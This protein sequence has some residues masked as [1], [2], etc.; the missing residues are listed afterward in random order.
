MHTRFV[1]KGERSPAALIRAETPAFGSVNN[2]RSRRPATA[3]LPRS[4]VLLRRSPWSA[5]VSNP[6]GRSEGST[7]LA[8]RRLRASDELS[9]LG[10]RS[11]RTREVRSNDGR[12]RGI[13]TRCPL[14]TVA[15][16]E[17]VMSIMPPRRPFKSPSPDE[18]VPPSRL[19]GRRDTG[20][21]S[22][23]PNAAATPAPG[24]TGARRRL[25]EFER[26][27]A[28]R[29]PSRQPLLLSFAERRVRTPSD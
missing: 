23:F 11:L 7:K 15:A 22:P 8:R 29:D 10:L 14:T 3:R 28:S 12:G 19:A 9:A 16:T 21:I 24:R 13:E 20:L 18:T 26:N 4:S 25:Q 6:R 1:L 5:E 27:S 2:P 17:R